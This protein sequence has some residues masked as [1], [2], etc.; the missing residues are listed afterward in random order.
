MPEFEDLPL[1]KDV[2]VVGAGLSGVDMGYRLQTQS[3]SD[4]LILEARG[5]IGGTWALHQYPGIRSDSDVYTLGFPFSP[6]DS[7]TG[8]ASGGAILDYIRGAAKNF[9]I[10]QRVYFHTK[11]VEASWNSKTCR[12]TLTVAGAGGEERAISTRFLAFTTGY[13]DFNNGLQTDIPGL[14]NFKGQIVHPQFWPSDLDATNKKFV[15][16]GSG[17]TAVTLV[18]SLAPTAE[19]ITMV[20]RTP[21]YM[22]AFPRKTWEVVLI[23]RLLPLRWSHQIVRIYKALQSYAFFYVCQWFPRLAR[24]VLRLLI[25]WQ[26]PKTIPLDP[27]FSPPYNPWDQRVCLVPDGDLFKTLRDGKAS[28]FTG[29]IKSFTEDSIVMENGETARADVVVTATGLKML[30]YGGATIKVDGEVVKVPERTMYNGTF[31]EG[32]PNSSLS[33]GY[34]NASWTLGA[35]VSA[36]YVCKALR[37]MKQNGFDAFVPRLDPSH[38]INAA[39]LLNLKS[40]YIRKAEKDIPHAGDKGPWRAKTFWPTDYIRAIKSPFNNSLI[41]LNPEKKAIA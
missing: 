39:P 9:G 40:N 35:D 6:W 17:A 31:L 21:T 1:E 34:T 3:E 14:S 16:I 25:S 30:V 38:G 28:I 15:V 8:I 12:W 10:D 27:H 13:Y 33:F 5:D 19:H 11:L 7:D 4:Y 36:L 32:V 24:F 29:K 18:P 37:F 20:Q 2:V 22:L 23:R 26:L 41:F